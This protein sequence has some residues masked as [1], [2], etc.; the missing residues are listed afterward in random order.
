MSVSRRDFM[1][2]VGVSVASLTLTHCRIPLPV[3]CY[4]PMPPSPSPTVPATARERLRLCWLSFDE[5]AQATIEEANQ[6]ATMEVEPIPETVIEGVQPTGVP[7]TSTENTFGQQLVARHRLALDEL[8]DAGELTPAVAGLV[9]E[10]YEAAVYHVWR[11][12]VPITCYAPVIVDYAPVSADVLVRQSEVLSGLVTQGNI[13]PQTLINAQTALEHDMA[14]YALTDDEIDG[15][16]DRITDEWQNQQQ[17][18]PTFENVSLEV[19]PD[20]KAAA[21]F[22]ISMLAGK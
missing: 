19:T 16:Y 21:R 4:A 3:T 8:I 2:L 20:A 12:N 6:G 5:L 17:A 1:K 7:K 18:V 13:D 22:I 15:L 11:S 14:Y 10:A 9:Q